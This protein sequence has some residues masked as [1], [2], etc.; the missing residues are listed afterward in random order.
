MVVVG[1]TALAGTS[2]AQ[3]VINEVDYEQAGLDDAEFIELHN[4][5]PAP[6]DLGGFVIELVDGSGAELEIYRSIELPPASVAPGALYC[7]C[8]SQEA[9]ANC[10]VVVGEGSELIR[11]GPLGAVGLRDAGGALLDTLSYEGSVAAPYTEGAG[12]TAGN[13]DL[14][15]ASIGRFPDGADTQD[16]SADFIG[17]CATPGEPNVDQIADCC[18]DG[19]VSGAEECDQARDNGK[20]PCGCRADCTLAPEASECEASA[21][22]IGVCD[23]A[24]N[25]VA[26]QLV[27]AGTPCGD[28]ADSDCTDIDTCD[29]AGNCVSNHAAD[30]LACDD[31]GDLLGCPGLCASG[32]CVARSEAGECLPLMCGD[33]VVE[34]PEECDDGNQLAGDGCDRCSREGGGGGGCACRS[35][36]AGGL[37]LGLLVLV[38]FVFRSLCFGGWRQQD[39]RTR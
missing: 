33:S 29:G 18:G 1:L 13:P 11:N 27:E 8:V 25:C 32:A 14:V 34:G 16:N 24:G 35:G 17:A 26:P 23:A 31:S 30:N 6:V 4:A 36:G 37:A 20:V 22:E 12:V 3:V 19:V 38:I 28:R 10:D 9:T 21:C 2:R 5:G 7:V 15:L 39:R